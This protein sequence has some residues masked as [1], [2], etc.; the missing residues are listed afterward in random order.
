[1]SN[2]IRCCDVS[3]V[4]QSSVE[5]A[6]PAPNPYLEPSLQ[7]HILPVPN[8]V[9]EHLFQR[10]EKTYH[11]TFNSFQNFTSYE[12]FATS[13]FLQVT[14][15]CLFQI[16]ISEEIDRGGEQYRRNKENTSGT[17]KKI[18]ID[19]TV[20]YQIDVFS[21]RCDECQQKFTF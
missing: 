4:T 12:L 17:I 18:G 13:N 1:M 8:L 9:A 20:G 11:A 10:Y 3:S 5:G 15:R 6:E 21:Y 14:C 16:C 2:L 19:L 7:T